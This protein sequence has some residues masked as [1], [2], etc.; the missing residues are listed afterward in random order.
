[1]ESQ[2][3][4][5]GQTSRPVQQQ[6]ARSSQRAA[7]GVYGWEEGGGGGVINLLFLSLEMALGSSEEDCEKGGLLFKDP[8]LLLQ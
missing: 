5:L 2:S 4:G 7:S 1:M 3:T 8:V 6:T